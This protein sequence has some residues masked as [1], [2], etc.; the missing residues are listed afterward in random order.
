MKQHSQHCSLQKKKRFLVVER[1]QYNIII[2]AFNG[3]Q[4]DE[5]GC[6]CARAFR[7]LRKLCAASSWQ[8]ININ[9]DSSDVNGGEIQRQ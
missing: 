9:N 5:F 6:E 7:G 2:G 3:V 8:T 4:S 1:T